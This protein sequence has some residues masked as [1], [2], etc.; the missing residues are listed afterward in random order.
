MNSIVVGILAGRG[1]NPSSQRV[2]CRCLSSPW[3]SKVVVLTS[4]P[5]DLKN[6]FLSI[7]DS[8]NFEFVL[9]P[10]ALRNK[11]GLA[12]QT[13]LREVTQISYDY[14]VLL[15]DDTVPDNRYFKFLSH[16]PQSDQ[17]ELLT[18][19]LINYDGTRCWDICSF[20][21]DGHPAVVPYEDWDNPKY[22]PGLYV[23]GPQHILNRKGVCLKVTYSDLDYGEDT[24]FC[25][26]FK[27][28]GGVM[29]LLPQMSC[30]LTHL[31]KKPN[32]F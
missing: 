25:K 21:E 6:P 7:Q 15:D 2:I 5:R 31:H 20:R 16:L 24:Q 11:R 27:K 19:K 14:S 3:V 4:L 12:R 32:F 18:G 9:F 22:E 13:L 23:S 17:P 29:R 30:K 28:A 10:P 1:I 8:S 26:H